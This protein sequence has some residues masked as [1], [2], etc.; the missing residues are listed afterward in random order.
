M[1]NIKHRKILSFLLTFL[2]VT[3]GLSVALAAGSAGTDMLQVYNYVYDE[4]LPDGSYAQPYYTDMNGNRVPG[5]KAGGVTAADDTLPTSYDARTLG[6]ITTPKYQAGAGSCWAFS[7][8]SCMETSMIKQGYTSLA[9]TDYSE[10]Y[11]TWFGQRQRTPDTTDPTYGDGRNA[12][13][14]FLTGGNWQNASAT[15]MRGSGVQ[16]EAN[17]PWI[18]TRDSDVMMQMAQPESDRY[19]SYGRIWKTQMTTDIAV[20]K[21]LLIECGSLYTNYYDDTGITNLG[22]NKANCC[23]YQNAKT[24]T[25]HAV[26]IVGWDDNFP[27]SNFNSGLRPTSNG[28]WLIKGSW[29]TR[30]GDGGYYWLSYEDPSNTEYTAITA[31]PA[32]IYDN[33]YQY[34]GAFCNST[35]NTNA[36]SAAMANLFYAK[37]NQL[38]TH[39][40]AFN[41][42]YGTTVR[43]QVYTGSTDYT[44]TNND[45]TGNM[46][47]RA[48]KTVYDVGYG[49]VTIP[50]TTPVQIQEGQ[51]FSVVITLTDTS[52]E[53]IRIPVEGSNPSSYTSNTVLHGGN[54]GESFFKSGSRWYDPNNWNGNDYN[55][56]PVKAMTRNLQTPTLTLNSLPAKTTYMV[57]ET[58]DTTGL[59]LTYSDELGNTSTVTTGFTCTPTTLNTIGTQTVTAT[60]NGV[61]TTFNVTVQP[62]DKALSVATLPD[63]TVYKVGQ[64]LDTTGL[65]LTYRNEYNTSSTVTTGYTCTPTTLSTIGT[66]TVTVTYSGV[67]TSFN[68]TVELYEK[69]LDAASLPAKTTYLVGETLDTTGL[70]LIYSDEYGNM[71]TVTGGFICTPTVLDTIGTQTVTV[72]Y[73][74]LT[75]TFDVTVQPYDETLSTATLPDKTVYKVGE[76]LDTTGLSLIYTDAYNM[77]STVMEG[78]TCTPTV[79]DTIGTQTVTVTYSGVT[80]TFDV[81]VQPYDQTLSATTLPDKTVYKVGETLDTTGLVLSYSD[82]YGVTSTVTAG[83]TCAPTTLDTIGTQTVT[84][85]YNGVT[86]TFD[87]T[88]QPYDETLSAATL[89]D[90]T[91]YKVGETLDTTGLVLSYSDIFGVTTTVTEGFTCAPTTLDTIGTQTVTVTYNGLTT[92]FDVTVEPYPTALA[93]SALPVKTEYVVGETLD[94]TGLALTYS[95]IYGVTSTVTTGFTCTPTTLDTVGT[96]TVTV[97]YNDLSTVFEVTVSPAPPQEGLLTVHDAAGYTGDTVQVTVSADVNPGVVAMR[98][99]VDYDNTALELTG[100]QNGTIFEDTN[101]TRCNDYAIRP[102]TLIWEHALSTENHTGTGTLATLT[103]RILDTAAAGDTAVT[104]ILDNESIFNVD[105]TEIPFNV[106]NGTVHISAS[107]EPAITVLTAKSGTSTVIDTDKG[108]IYGLR[109][110][111]T[112]DDLDD[113]LAVQ[114]GS[115]RV[116]SGAYLGTGSVV[117]VLDTQGSVVATYSVVIFGDVDG[118]GVATSDD[119]RAIKGH[120]NGADVLPPDSSYLLAA[121]VDG[122][123]SVDLMDSL[124]IKS[125]L[126][127]SA[128]IDQATRR[129]SN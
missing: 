52:G 106:Q 89:P 15:I 108:F 21:Q 43:A 115:Y 9:D 85:T 1:R 119:I 10:A 90:K 45:P 64:T 56:V 44:V 58:L 29:S 96:Q 32:D 22:Y 121:D 122:D 93:V 8:I 39:V 55:N 127:G 62:Y 80:T 25:N 13:T 69:A 16:L 30:Y 84:V 31:V 57:G 118:D 63:K 92:A 5:P 66:Q 35:L 59:S 110:D 124:A 61:T 117:E 46:T 97:T 49:Y 98:M 87:V 4:Q 51:A 81:T 36:S 129:L 99:Y 12:D 33:I 41:P 75:T 91:V 20:A 42:N 123:G 6:I 126:N 95:D 17:A 103:F 86:T 18:E 68:V 116:I 78:F 26:T 40:A 54:V 102:F 3:Q 7:T 38:V 28:A 107:P 24:S 67:T 47:L 112:P 82:I 23:Y 101:F 72:T 105:M 73:N 70:S 14:P 128:T 111:M 113:Y 50:L 100:V 48:S 37:G 19:L 125:I 11:M 76:T 104:L 2:M 27:A 79:L 34:D 94:T 114:G 109:F 60:Y 88:V 120:M 53:S 71:S 74:G 65:S 83:F 77:S